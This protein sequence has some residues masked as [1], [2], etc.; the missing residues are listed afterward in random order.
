MPKD[1]F[2]P[3][4]PMELVS[5]GVPVDADEDEM[6]ESLV[7]EYVLQGFDRPRLMRLFSDPF[8]TLTHGIHLR[9]GED[10]VRAA[11]DRVLG[12]FAGEAAPRSTQCPR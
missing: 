4:D 6:V 5:L 10:Y 9:R 3:E 12:R 1:D 7:L 8:Y 11:I 2:D